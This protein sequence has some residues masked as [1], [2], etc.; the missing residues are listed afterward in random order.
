MK[1]FRRQFQKNQSGAQGE[2]NNSPSQ[3]VP[4]QTITL[5]Q[6]LVNHTRGIPS[7]TPHIEGHYTG[8][9]IPVILDLNDMQRLR[10]DLAEK[11]KE[12]DEKIFIEKE[13]K[14]EELKK[15]KAEKK[16]KKEALEASKPE[17]EVQ[18]EK[19]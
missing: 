17:D 1:A 6:L 14:A 9:E 4:D 19:D 18:P 5:K 7:N 11:Q 3:T 16:A 15:A 2:V 12:L 10:D 13:L 8:T